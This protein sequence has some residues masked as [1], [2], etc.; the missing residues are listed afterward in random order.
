VTRRLLVSYLSLTFV[1]L[2][3]LELPLG[4]Y[5]ARSERRDV[6]S[7]LERDAVTLATYARTRWRATARCPQTSAPSSRP[8]PTRPRPAW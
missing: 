7:R 6:T 5:V 4:V 1:V 8:T 2:L 3:V